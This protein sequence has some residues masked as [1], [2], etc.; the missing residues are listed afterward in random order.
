VLLF[1]GHDSGLCIA[2]T[3]NSIQLE[4]ILILINLSVIRK[5]NNKNQGK[6][7]I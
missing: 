6:I 3:P 1:N 7:N 2:K 5:E 4:L